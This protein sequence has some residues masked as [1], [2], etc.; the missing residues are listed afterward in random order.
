MHEVGTIYFTGNGLPRNFQMAL[1]WWEKAAKN[2]Y[3]PSLYSL[4]RAYREGKGVARHLR[5]A[6]EFWAKA[7]ERGH[8]EAAYQLGNLFAEDGSEM[9]SLQ[10]AAIWWHNA[11]HQGHADAQYQIATLYESGAYSHVDV[12]QSSEVAF[13]WY[14]KAVA[15]GHIASQQKLIIIIIIIIGDFIE[16]C[17]EVHCQIPFLRDKRHDGTTERK[18]RKEYGRT[19][20]NM[21]MKGTVRKKKKRSKHEGAAARARACAT[22]ASSHR[23]GCKTACSSIIRLVRPVVYLSPRDGG[24]APPPTDGHATSTGTRGTRPGGRRADSCATAAPAN[25]CRRVGGNLA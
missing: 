2:D 7:A 22:R 23:C 1:S 24:G 15:Q 20:K 6:V 21:D 25:R 10:D 3:N 5:T 17:Y 19:R 4:G 16:G 12:E 9:R 13:Q 14:Q 18:R 11:A 8:S